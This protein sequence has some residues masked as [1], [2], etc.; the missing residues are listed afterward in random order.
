[1]NAE[2]AQSSVQEPPKSKKKNKAGSKKSS[3]TTKTGNKQFKQVEEEKDNEQSGVGAHAEG[4]AASALSLSAQQKSQ[5]QMQQNKQDQNEHKV[6]R[7]FAAALRKLQDEGDQGEKTGAT[8]NSSENELV[9]L[10]RYYKFVR[11]VSTYAGLP[12]QGR[13]CPSLERLTKE[14]LHDAVSRLLESE[15]QSRL[16]KDLEHLGNDDGTAPTPKKTSNKKSAVQPSHQQPQAAITTG[17]S[18]AN[19]SLPSADG[20]PASTS[21]APDASS[22]TNPQGL[23]KSQLK[24]HKKK[25]RKR[26]EA[27]LA[28]GENEDAREEAEKQKEPLSGV[29]EEGVSALEF[30]EIGGA[31]SAE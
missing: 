15:W 5:A 21:A 13:R 10:N 23:S 1:M 2:L 8:G 19:L 6:R 18:A 31:T 17:A 27:Q 26:K 4:W 9:R 16:A 28:S 30:P 29:E 11:E 7:Y 20:K 25:N 14:L 24:K 12:E 3:A 22:A